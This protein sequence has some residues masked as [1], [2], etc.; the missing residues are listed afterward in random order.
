MA[1][2]ELKLPRSVLRGENLYVGDDSEP[3][4]RI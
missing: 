4:V 1:Y 3:F 2:D